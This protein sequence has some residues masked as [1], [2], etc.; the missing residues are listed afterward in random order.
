M[1]RERESPPSGIFSSAAVEDLL[2][3]LG[4]PIPNRA[5][6]EGWE[7]PR[8]LVLVTT[9]AQNARNREVIRKTWG[10]VALRRD[11]RLAF[12]A[13][14]APTHDRRVQDSLEE[15]SRHFGDIIQAD[16]IDRYDNLTLKAVSILEWTLN[17]CA[18]ITFLLKTDDDMF[19]NT[20]QLLD[21]IDTHHAA[22]NTIFGFLFTNGK[23]DRNPHSKWHVS[24]SEYPATHYPR[25]VAGP[26]YLLTSDTL[27]PLWKS[28]L[29]HPF[30]KLEDVFLTGLIA[31]NLHIN[32]LGDP[33]FFN[34]VPDSPHRA[35]SVI[36]MH[37]VPLKEFY[38]V[39]DSVCSSSGSREADCILKLCALRALALFLFLK[40]PFI[41]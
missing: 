3:P 1:P 23:P 31:Q 33:K 29:P 39:W 15:E 27:H 36:S 13:A 24:E 6:C 25:F 21:F 34:H 10:H 30:F 16:F 41:G 22:I 40:R 7:T 32:R 17:Y 19:I 2:H 4:F 8:L 14:L 37:G 38:N 9:R 35:R 28:A 5:L 20:F 26:A 11:V 12:F 18:N